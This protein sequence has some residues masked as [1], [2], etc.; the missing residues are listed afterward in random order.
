MEEGTPEG[1]KNPWRYIFKK[2]EW[3]VA[4]PLNISNTGA[5]FWGPPLCVSS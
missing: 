5:P 1:R 2:S 3:K 4:I